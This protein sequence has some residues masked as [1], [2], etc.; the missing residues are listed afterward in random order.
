MLNQS[1]ERSK[2]IVKFGFKN[3]MFCGS[4]LAIWGTIHNLSVDSIYEYKIFF[5]DAPSLRV[6]A[7][8]GGSP[9]ISRQM[10]PG[11]YL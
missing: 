8:Y 9:Q 7:D 4:K 2:S 3:N 6:D 11:A 1:F 5:W 10:S